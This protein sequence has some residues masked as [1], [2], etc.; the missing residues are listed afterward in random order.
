MLAIRVE[1]RR[2][3]RRMSVVLAF[4]LVVSV[5]LVRSPAPAGA[6]ATNIEQCFLDMINDA[7]ADVGAAALTWAPDIEGYTRDHSIDM[8]GWGELTHST[9]TDLG[10]ALP[11]GWTSWG[12]N[13]GW[14]S[15]PNPPDCAAMHEAFMD[16][17]G[18]R[19]N[20]LNAGF[21]FAATGTYID[22]A[23]ELWT[24]HVFFSDS[25]YV[26]GFNGTFSDDDNST[27]EEDIE[28]IAE[29]GITSG[30]GGDL[31]C[32]ND[33]VS[34]AQMAAF[35]NRALDLPAG[36]D[37]GFN[38]VGGAFEDDINAIAYADITEGCQPS[39]YCPNDSLSRAQMAAFLVRAFDLPPGPTAGFGDAAGHLFED[40]INSLVAAG[41]TLGCDGGTN[42]CPNDKVTRGQMAAFLARALGL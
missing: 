4:L 26:P 19:D 29:E 6:A 28:K 37:A 27:F 30:C 5:L 8:S 31:Y 1:R 24:T 7:R 34:R 22:G 2:V 18:H 3:T 25:S 11:A 12:E 42:F 40:E 36:P 38:D 15:H 21:E 32:P 20:L 16:S 17:S 33:P 35:L 10:A 14:Q 13:I 23:G 39:M 41:I 9:G